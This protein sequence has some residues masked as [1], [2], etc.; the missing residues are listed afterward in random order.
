MSIFAQLLLSFSRNNQKSEI[1]KRSRYIFYKIVDHSDEWKYLL[2]CINTKATFQAEIT[3]IVFE[4]KILR[5]LHPVQS[6]YIGIEYSKFLKQT[7]HSPIKR[8]SCQEDL[9]EHPISRYGSYS[10]CYQNRKSEICFIHKTTL[11]EFFMDA[12][13][14]AL[15]EELITEFDSTESFYIGM[16]AGFKLP[17]VHSQQISR[18]RLKI[19]K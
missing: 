13:D 1:E 4:K 16:I 3:D 15:S 7:Q 11:E 2:Q 14:I 12:R 8:S 17:P 10:L 9:I 19:I 5:G 18:P 6:C